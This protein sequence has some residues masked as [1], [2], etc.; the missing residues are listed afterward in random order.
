[1][2]GRG[3]E[4]R[5][6]MKR[7][8]AV[9][10]GVQVHGQ[11]LCAKVTKL[12]SQVRVDFVELLILDLE[13]KK[14]LSG[15]QL[16]WL[17]SPKQYALTTSSGVKEFSVFEFSLTKMRAETTSHVLET[18]PSEELGYCLSTAAKTTALRMG[19]EHL[20]FSTSF[21]PE[22]NHTA[23]W[24]QYSKIFSKRTRDKGWGLAKTCDYFSSQT[25]L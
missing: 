7:T 6:C 5:R 8:T 2:G 18:V 9:M 20:K 24:S 16:G 11:R 22:H 13:L 12:Q 4:A 3:C 1:M 17:W 10:R 21:K 19:L 15:Y 14:H 23:A 25:C